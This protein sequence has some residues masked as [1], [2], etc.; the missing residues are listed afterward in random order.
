[1]AGSS[2]VTIPDPGL[3]ALVGV[4][5]A[6][7]SRFAARHFTPDEVLS[8]DAYREAI[9]GDAADQRA[10]RPAFAAL[11]RALARRLGTGRLTV[12]DA[13]N[14]QAPARRRLLQAAMQA[15]VPAVA[16]VLDLPPA[17][18]VERNAGRDRTVPAA[19]IHRQLRDLEETVATGR[20]ESEG[21]AAVIRLATPDAVDA[22]EVIRVRS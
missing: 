11:H 22:V 15:G 12:V 20:L 3:V 6:G 13:T 5:G 16:I 10:T 19:A 18:V 14:V 7:K 1:V 17:L 4:A 2:V 8:S 21:F 9:A